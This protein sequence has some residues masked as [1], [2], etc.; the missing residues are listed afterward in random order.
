MN[1]TLNFNTEPDTRRFY[2]VAS[3]GAPNFGDE[4]ITRAWLDWLAENHPTAE[5]WLDCI[6]P[7]RATHLFADTHPRL[8]VTN[9]LWQLAHTEVLSDLT[10]D[11]Q[12]AERL[13][14]TLG[15]PQYDLGLEDLRQMTSVHFLGG[16]Y[17]NSLWE[18]NLTMVAAAAELRRLFGVPIYAT[19]A[20]L[21]PATGEAQRH[22]SEGFASFDVV[23]ARDAPSA[24]TF[25]VR[26]GIDDAFLAFGT[27]RRIF[28]DYPTPDRMVLIQGDFV[29]DEQREHLRTRIREMV[30][31]AGSERIGFVEAYP[32][33][34]AEFVP[35]VEET[36]NVDFFPFMRIW[37]EGL[38]MRPGQSWLTTR[39]H[40]HLLAAAAGAAGLALAADDEYY[41]VK[42][43][44]LTALGT[45][46]RVSS[47]DDW[48]ASAAR[49]E[50]SGSLPA[51]RLATLVEQKL[52]LARVL[53]G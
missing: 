53:Y 16:G 6:H 48:L 21:M 51:E 1:A 40:F 43:G 37:Q 10:A 35:P 18:T 33:R 38:P 47:L 3:A 39:F 22:L 27:E 20:G 17:L 24:E 13:I 42:H 25:G 19:G 9:T 32:P 31:E 15:S 52:T 12:R 11:R 45:G 50:A 30:R 2:L 46:W 7:G 4:F 28:G 8:R 5:V 23:E 44:S 36:P 49:P 41:A 14:A 26:A 29:A 34:D